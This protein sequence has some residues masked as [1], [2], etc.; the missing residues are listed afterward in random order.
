MY[1]LNK[2]NKFSLGAWLASCNYNHSSSNS[3]KVEDI[4]K[5]RMVPFKKLS[6][7]IRNFVLMHLT[8]F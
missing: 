1:H 2:I 5:F 6:E 4:N 7:P 8:K 3:F